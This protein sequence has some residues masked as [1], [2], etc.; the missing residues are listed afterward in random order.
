MILL[1]L[2]LALTDHTWPT[3]LSSRRGGSI[4]A[5]TIFASLPWTAA[6]KC[7]SNLKHFRYS[8]IKYSAGVDKP[9]PA[10]S[11]RK[12]NWSK[13]DEIEL[14]FECAHGVNALSYP[15]QPLLS[16]LTHGF[17]KPCWIPEIVVGSLMR[18]SACFRM[19]SFSVGRQDPQTLL[20]PG[21]NDNHSCVGCKTSIKRFACDSPCIPE[22]PTN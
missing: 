9:T 14:V 22:C 10:E 19:C 20:P 6:L 3:L 11:P 7:V 21:H 13:L 16:L 15:L 5:T 8:S 1:F 4:W 12:G 17:S 18:S 2:W